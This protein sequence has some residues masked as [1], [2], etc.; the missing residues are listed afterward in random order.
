MT[1][2]NWFFISIPVIWGIGVLLGLWLKNTG[3]GQ[4]SHYI[5]IAF[6]ISS[7]LTAISAYVFL[8]LL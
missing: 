3:G 6:G 4:P 8:Y 5:G 1:Y 7:V 2:L